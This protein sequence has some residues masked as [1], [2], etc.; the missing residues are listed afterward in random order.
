MTIEEDGVGSDRIL[1]SGMTFFGFH[2]TQTAER[3]LGQR[4]IVDVSM[5]C[6]L[7][8]ASLSD[9]LA[10]TIDYSA[11]YRDVRNIV[12]GPPV[13]LTEVVAERIATEILG[14]YTLVDAVQ[15]RV[16]KPEVRLD[17][18]VLAGSTIEIM[19]RREV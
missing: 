1:L 13:G 3:E 2:G 16:T 4:L 15:V 18:G 11:A 5:E 12:E 8:P 9:D 7:R 19:R 17:G 10:H 6:D 14:N